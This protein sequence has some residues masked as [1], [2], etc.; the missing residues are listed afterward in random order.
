MSVVQL[1][2]GRNINVAT[3]EV[4]SVARDAR[5]QDMEYQVLGKRPQKMVDCH[6]NI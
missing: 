3:S 4:H 2:S 6:G 5:I 1:R